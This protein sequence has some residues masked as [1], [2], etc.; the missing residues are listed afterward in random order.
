MIKKIFQLGA[1]VLLSVGSAAV[2]AAAVR[3][4]GGRLSAVH[5]ATSAVG[6][7][8]TLDVSRVSGEKFFTLEH[9]FRAVIDLPHT[10]VRPG[11]RLPAARGLVAGIR[12]GRRPHGALRVVLVLHD[13]AGVHADW[14]Y[15]R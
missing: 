10:H 11:L 2:P 7:R 15:S 8:V 3:A 13:P 9:P 12:V 6:A 4:A 1:I 14:G 5:L